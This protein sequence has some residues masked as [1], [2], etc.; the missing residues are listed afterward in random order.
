MFGKLFVLIAAACALAACES[1]SGAVVTPP[2]SKTGTAN[3]EQAPV[4]YMVFFPLGS[5]MEN[6]L[7]SAVVG[8]ARG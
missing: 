7:S 8:P 4:S 6:R 3:N 5:T 1:Q 2:M